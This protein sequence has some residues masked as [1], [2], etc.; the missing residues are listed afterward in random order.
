MFTSLKEREKILIFL[1][2]T[3]VK[4]MWDNSRIHFGNLKANKYMI[5]FI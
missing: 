4:A 2:G 1:G 3:V 5:A